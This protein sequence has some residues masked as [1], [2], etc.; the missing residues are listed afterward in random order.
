MDRWIE[1]LAILGGGISAIT[2]SGW[3]L[4]RAIKRET[5]AFEEQAAEVDKA[6]AVV[7]AELQLYRLEVSRLQSELTAV[8]YAVECIVEGPP[9][10]RAPPPSQRAS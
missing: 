3:L 8:R 6:L 7:N 10:L 9:S 1:V 2:I 4:G 5:R